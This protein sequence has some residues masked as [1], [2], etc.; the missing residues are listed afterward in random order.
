M[1]DA[2]QRTRAASIV[3]IVAGLILTVPGFTVGFLGLTDM[4]PSSPQGSAAL[5]ELLGYAFCTWA[6]F[7]AIK[8]LFARFLSDVLASVGYLIASFVLAYG[9]YLLM[10][11]IG[12]EASL[13]HKQAFTRPLQPLGW[14]CLLLMSIWAGIRLWRKMRSALTVN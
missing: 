8:L 5:A 2:A 7:T 3:S 9:F 13:K 1:V 11:V 14:L 10:T 4:G 12:L 6:I